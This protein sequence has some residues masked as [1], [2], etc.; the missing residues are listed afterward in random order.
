MLVVYSIY[1]YNLL[2]IIYVMLYNVKTIQ[3]MSWCQWSFCTYRK[4]WDMFNVL[5]GLIMQAG[6]IVQIGQSFLI[7]TTFKWN[8]LTEQSPSDCHIIDAGYVDA[9][10][11]S[12]IQGVWQKSEGFTCRDNQ[13][14]KEVICEILEIWRGRT[15]FIFWRGVENFK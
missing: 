8:R 14:L 7:W 11:S 3:Y 6:L 2:C 12:G 5:F 4:V 15:L 9:C 1:K 13:N 10:P